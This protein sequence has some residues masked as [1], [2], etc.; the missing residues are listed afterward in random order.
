VLLVKISVIIPSLNE[1]ETIT[2][3]IRSAKSG[4]PDVE[5]IVVDGGSADGTVAVAE[6]LGATT[7]SAERGRGA[8][9]DAGASASTGEVLL[10]L[11]ADSRLPDAWQHK[12]QEV[13]AAPGV[14]AGGFRLSIDSTNRALA[15]VAA[16]ANLRARALGLIYGD[17][18]I[19]A[20]KESFLRAGGYAKLPLMEDVYCVKKL[21][22]L[23]RVVLIDETVRTSARRWEGNSILRCTLR[24]WWLLALWFAGLS[25]ERLHGWYYRKKPGR[26]RPGRNR[27][28]AG[29]EQG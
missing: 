14:V 3:A 1:A 6:G 4:A 15:I 16:G 8:Q 18:A 7:I 24:N 20:S 26:K 22:E 5:V 28:G 27:N 11:H 9:M 29:Q 2:E 10:F 25:P 13:M 17:Q 12:V 23:G 19:F 21:R